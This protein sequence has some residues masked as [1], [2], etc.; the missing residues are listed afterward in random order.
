MHRD[1]TI[2]RY[3]LFFH[4]FVYVFSWEMIFVINVVEVGLWLESDFLIAIVLNSWKQFIL[5]P[6]SEYNLWLHQWND[7]FEVLEGNS[8]LSLI[9]STYILQIWFQFLLY[10]VSW[11][12]FLLI[13][14][15]GLMES[16]TNINSCLLVIQRGL[17]WVHLSFVTTAFQHFEI[18]IEMLIMVLKYHQLEICLQS[19]STAR[20]L[21]GLRIAARLGM[22]FSKDTDTAIRDLSSSVEKLD[23]VF[24]MS[25]RRSSSYLNFLF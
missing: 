21:R 24:G 4:S 2:N 9:K 23:K 8:L 22:S 19:L 11:Y 15:Y 10:E 25:W 14:F 12:W 13:L 5:R 20:I 3:D 16:A 1:F 17:W 7:R 6:F 18:L